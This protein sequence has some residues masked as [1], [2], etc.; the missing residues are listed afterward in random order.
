MK[1]FLPG[2]VVLAAKDKFNCSWPQ[3]VTNEMN[4]DSMELME[5]ISASFDHTYMKTNGKS[6]FR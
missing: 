4:F 2:L 6:R 5:T 3:A 1:A